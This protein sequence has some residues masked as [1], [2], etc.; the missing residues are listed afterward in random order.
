MLIYMRP[1]FLHRAPRKNKKQTNKQQQQ[2]EKQKA[3]SSDQDVDVGI[4]SPQA[5]DLFTSGQRYITMRHVWSLSCWGYH[6]SRTSTPVHWYMFMDN[7]SW[8]VVFN[9]LSFLLNSQIHFMKVIF[10]FSIMSL[11]QIFPTACWV[12]NNDS[13]KFCIYAINIQ[14]IVNTINEVMDKGGTDTFMLR[15]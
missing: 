5:L 4:F 9:W 13:V 7:H 1:W 15:T 3:D 11:F 12:I 6:A 10:K 2:E 14:L 8:T